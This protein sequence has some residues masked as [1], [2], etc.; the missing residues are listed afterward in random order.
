MS[1]LTS[2]QHARDPMDNDIVVYA[3][4]DIRAAVTECISLDKEGLLAVSISRD[5]LKVDFAVLEFY[6]TDDDGGVLYERVFEGEG[7]AG[8]LR[9]LRHTW[10]GEADNAGYIFYPSMRLIADALKHLGKWFD[11]P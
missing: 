9:E 10:W 6:S 1:L 5:G 7:Y 3:D 2:I 4:A 8:S 11:E